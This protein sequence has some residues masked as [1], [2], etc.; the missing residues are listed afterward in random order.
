MGMFSCQSAHFIK[1]EMIILVISCSSKI[2]SIE[3]NTLSVPHMQ[4]PL[5]CV[6][7]HSYSR[8]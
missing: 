2:L 1:Y 7:I 8:D 4:V 6:V 5:Q 3:F